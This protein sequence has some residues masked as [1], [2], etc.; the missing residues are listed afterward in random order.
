MTSTS[1]SFYSDL[2]SK[3]SINKRVLIK[4][5]FSNKKILNCPRLTFPVKQNRKKEL[6]SINFK[7]I[8]KKN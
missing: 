5:F 8:A 4:P 2:L 7:T 3:T 6:Q 1:Q